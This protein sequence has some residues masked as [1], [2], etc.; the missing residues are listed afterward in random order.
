MEKKII[1]EAERTTMFN[2]WLATQEMPAY[3]SLKERQ[4]WWIRKVIEFD[5][6][7]LKDYDVIPGYGDK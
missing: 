7:F 4:Q 1:S 5:K 6:S 3:N 2:Q